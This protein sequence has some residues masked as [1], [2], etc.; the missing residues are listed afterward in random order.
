[1]SWQQG[2]TPRK[3]RALSCLCLQV[4]L[5]R[6]LEPN[7]KLSPDPLTIHPSIHPTW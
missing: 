6:E 1:M 2:I 3:R 4:L 5:A 7:R